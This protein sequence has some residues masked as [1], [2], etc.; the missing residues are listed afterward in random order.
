MFPSASSDP[1]IT[2]A[3]DSSSFWI[4]LRLL[5]IPNTSPAAIKKAAAVKIFFLSSFI[6]SLLNIFRGIV[7]P[8]SILPNQSCKNKGIF[9]MY[10]LHYNLSPIFSQA[11]HSPS[12]TE[13]TRCQINRSLAFC[14]Q[15]F[16]APPTCFHCNFFKIMLYLAKSVQRPFHP[17]RQR[18]QHVQFNHT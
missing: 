5:V 10:A 11:S 9:V 1:L 12:R 14:R 3:P 17:L 2:T 16:H 7:L 15:I 4:P 13:H 8:V 18:K 6:H